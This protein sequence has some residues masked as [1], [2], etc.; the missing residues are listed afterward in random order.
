MTRGT[1]GAAPTA[2]VVTPPREQW[3]LEAAP[4]AA[5]YAMRH[6]CLDDLST[7]FCAVGEYCILNINEFCK[8]Q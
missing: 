1:I 5:S 3:P 4:R 6:A 8:F 2:G 7:P